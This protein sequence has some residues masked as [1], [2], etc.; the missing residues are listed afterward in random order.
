M[1]GRFLYA[2]SIKIDFTG[3]YVS[4]FPAAAYYFIRFGLFAPTP[5]AVPP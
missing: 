4:I 2:L 5:Q 3:Y 1:G